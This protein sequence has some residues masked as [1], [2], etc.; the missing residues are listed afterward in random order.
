MRILIL[1]VK[2]GDGH[3]AAARA[4]LERAEYEGHQAEIVDFLGL[5]S[6][7]IS[8]AVNGTYV[9]VVKYFPSLF[10]ACYQLCGSMSR[11]LGKVHSPLYLDSAI[12]SGRLLDYLTLN[13]PY[14][15][16]VATHL[17]PAQALSYLKK[18]GCLLPLTVAVAT[19]YTW[20]PFWQE[21]EMCDCYVL[22]HEDLVDSYVKRG[23]P[24][25]KLYP[26]GIPVGMRFLDLPT[27]A[28]ARAEL[29][30]GEQTRIYL[31]MGGGM[32]A[33]NIKKLVKELI[34]RLDSAH[35]IVICGRNQNLRTALEKMTAGN[36][37]VHIVGYTNRVSVYM[38]ACDVLYTKPGGVS[39]AEALVCQ[40][41]LVHTAPIPGCESDNY[42]FFESRECALSAKKWNWQIT[43]GIRLMASPQLRQ[44]MKTAQKRC[45]KPNAARDILRLIERKQ[46]K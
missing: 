9:A 13:G 45:A 26:F 32:G 37:S 36:R 42:D 22:P 30:F 23:V 46:P 20:Y 7:R 12:V 35:L 6:D 24:R 40:I 41:P 10:G 29:G 3:D 17:M 21:T 8:K 16:I 34:P 27:R 1:S 15:G 28:Q 19:D 11:C 31:V 38:R 5:F 14:D 4:V 43:N 33:G 2:A 39:S 25:E 18:N 44:R